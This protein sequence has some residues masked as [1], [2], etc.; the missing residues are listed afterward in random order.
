MK[1]VAGAPLPCGRAI[2]SGRA[3]ERAFPVKHA[4]KKKGRTPQGVRPF[5]AT[6]RG[7]LYMRT[8]YTAPIDDLRNFLKVAFL[9]AAATQLPNAVP[10]CGA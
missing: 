3:R 6:A 7:G 8:G 4:P 1:V 5:E 10:A 2:G 9:R